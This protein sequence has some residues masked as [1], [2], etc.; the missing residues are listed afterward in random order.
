M[1]QRLNSLVLNTDQYTALPRSTWF[2]ASQYLYDRVRGTTEGI[3]TIS[4]SSSC[5]RYLGYFSTPSAPI[6]T[7]F[8]NATLICCSSSQLTFFSVLFT[9]S[10]SWET[11]IKNISHTEKSFLKSHKQTIKRN[12]AFNVTWRFFVPIP[13]IPL[14]SHRIG[15]L[16]IIIKNYLRMTRNACERQRTLEH[17]FYM[18][19]AEHLKAL[20]QA[21]WHVLDLKCSFFFFFLLLLPIFSFHSHG[22]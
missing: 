5:I 14:S 13:Q 12:Y 17:F 3:K 18:R 21:R 11:N 2:L 20:R 8:L 4:C 16:L 7:E 22:E 1:T 9:V 15:A 6:A 19:E 10:W